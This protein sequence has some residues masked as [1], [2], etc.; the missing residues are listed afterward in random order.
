MDDSERR[1]V[2]ELV[3]GLLLSDGELHPREAGFLHRVL[4]HFGMPEDTSVKPVIDRH[5]AVASLR[6]LDTEDQQETLQLLIDAAA[7][8]GQIA[9]AER[10]FLGALASELSVAEADLDSR[11]RRALEPK[12]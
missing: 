8:D 6:A 9:P 2:C 10:I 12:N 7:A 5:A 1:R 4:G 3:A 11:L